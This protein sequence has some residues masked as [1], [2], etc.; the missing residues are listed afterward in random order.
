[1]DEARALLGLRL[2]RGEV[3][4]LRWADLDW[5][6]K[7]IK[8][9][10]QVQL[11]A[12]K[13][14]ISTPRTEGSGRPLPLTAGMIARLERKREPQKAERE[15]LGEAWKEHGL[16]FATELGTPTSPRNLNRTFDVARTRAKLTGVRLHD[17]RHA[18]ATL[19]GELGVAE[20]VIGALLGYVPSNI[21]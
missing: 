1:V 3:L 15:A 12:K 2:R 21:T 18:F 4:G 8:V 14:V 17:L 10:Q 19:L 20:G 7:T 13:V 5:E 9:T 6:A 16:I 11:V